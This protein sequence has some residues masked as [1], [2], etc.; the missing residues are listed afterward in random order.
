LPSLRNDNAISAT[1]VAAC[2]TANPYPG[3]ITILSAFLSASAAP[4][5]SISVWT[6]ISCDADDG[7]VT[8]VP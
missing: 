8:V 4:L 5:A 1:T 6:K 3:T 7:A 2:A